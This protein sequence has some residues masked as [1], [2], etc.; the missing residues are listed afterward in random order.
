MTNHLPEEHIGS[1]CLHPC[2]QNSRFPCGTELKSR[3]ESALGAA[4]DQPAAYHRVREVAPNKTMYCVTF[5]PPVEIAFE[6]ERAPDAK[7]LKLE[8]AADD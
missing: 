1:I 8:E 5:V 7:R 3:L 4:L 6:D 2:W